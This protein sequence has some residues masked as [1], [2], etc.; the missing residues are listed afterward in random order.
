V[1]REPNCIHII[2]TKPR[3]NSTIHNSVV[4]IQRKSES[5][6]LYSLSIPS[7]SSSSSLSDRIS[8][9]VEQFMSSSLW[10]Y[11]DVP[12]V[13]SVATLS[14]SSKSSSEAGS[15]SGNSNSNQLTATSRNNHNNTKGSHKSDTQ[16]AVIGFVLEIGALA[17]AAWISSW[18]I[19]RV[20]NSRTT[21]GADS[22][23][24]QATATAAEKRLAKLLAQRGRQLPS[25]LTRYE[26]LMAEDVLDPS[27]IS[28]KFADIGGMNAMKQEL[29][30]L[31]ILPLR[32]PDLFASSKLLS[33]PGGILLYGPPGTGKTMLAKAIAKEA[34]ATFLTIKLSKIMNKWFG[35]SNKLIDATF[36]LATKLA[37]S[38]I[39]IDELDTF[40]NPRDGTEGSAG[41]AIK[42]EFLTLWDGMTTHET[43]NVLVLGAT[44]RPN[45]VDGAILRR[46]P[47]VFR[48]ALPN[49]A[50]RLH[51]LQLTLQGHPLDK[52]VPEFLPT[53]AKRI[54][55][56][57]GSDIKE[58]C[59]CAALE[60]VR[61][62]A[63]ETAIQA[64]TAGQ[65][66]SALVEEAKA[67]ANATLRSMSRNDLLLAMTKVKRTGQDAA[68]YEQLQQQGGD[69]PLVS[70]RRR[71][72]KQ[73]QSSSQQQR[74]LMKS[75]LT[76]SQLLSSDSL[77]SAT[78]NNHNNSNDSEND[79][80]EEDDDA[81]PE[82]KDV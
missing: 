22:V 42:A 77:G 75:L 4:S 24:D 53:L 5:M 51:I 43:A 11:G 71:Q 12:S 1:I 33:Q 63:R 80:D 2:Q 35:E 60:A 44:N 21:G 55:G 17:I 68:E 28:T 18:L 27:D 19:G 70:S 16:A 13:G 15:G 40:L 9:H 65:K 73:Q 6:S 66:E 32:R 25:T 54:V 30:E 47:R 39:F 8:K 50:G 31:A 61:E 29:W 26:S 7:A 72:Q 14:S 49:E 62:V 38:I 79:T 37:P 20:L 76:L 82:L 45:H 3:E 56:Y 69:D 23:E 57:S 34:G 46:L 52:D 59:K 78:S 10:G 48:I 81:I 64:V 36:S 74:Q 67:T 41:N 58:L